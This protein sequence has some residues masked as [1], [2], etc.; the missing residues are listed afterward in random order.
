MNPFYTL[1]RLVSDLHLHYVNRGDPAV[2]DW[3]IADFTKDG[4]W[5]PLL[6]TLTT[7]P[8]GAELVHFRGVF[9]SNAPGAGF[10][11]RTLGNVNAQNVAQLKTQVAG[12]AITTDFLCAP[13]PTNHI[14]YNAQAGVFTLLSLTLRG[15]WVI[16]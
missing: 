7:W 16:T 3:T 10:R 14:E 4:A 13:G 12:L 8:V 11:L 5:H 2:P 9:V 6:K 15:W 1:L